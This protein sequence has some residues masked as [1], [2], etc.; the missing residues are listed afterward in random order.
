[1]WMIAWGKKSQPNKKWEFGAEQHVVLLPCLRWR[2]R[3]E[4]GRNLLGP[5]GTLDQRPDHKKIIQGCK[6]WSRQATLGLSIKNFLGCKPGVTTVWPW[7]L[8]NVLNVCVPFFPIWWPLCR[9]EGSALGGGRAPTLQV[10]V[11]SWCYKILKEPC[12]GRQN[13]RDTNPGVPLRGL[14]INEGKKTMFYI[15]L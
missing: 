15:H 12:S 1:M 2:S 11:S 4:F 10:F 9:E 8:C 13:R 14:Y 3:L 6:T 5:K 7:P